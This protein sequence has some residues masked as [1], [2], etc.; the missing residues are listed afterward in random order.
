[1]LTKI[2]RLKVYREAVEY[3]DN[4]QENGS[5]GLC[6]VLSK[7]YWRTFMSSPI[8]NW[9]DM[10]DYFPELYIQGNPQHSKEVNDFT[11]SAAERVALRKQMCINAIAQLET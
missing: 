6:I 8:C 4:W 9:R 3:Y 1:M 11:A 5:I 10:E 2:Q 7:L